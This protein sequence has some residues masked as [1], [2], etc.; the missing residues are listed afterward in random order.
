MVEAK[1]PYLGGGENK[2]SRGKM[3]L[4]GGVSARGSMNLRGAAPPDIARY[5]EGRKGGREE[6]KDSPGRMTANR[7]KGGEGREREHGVEGRE[8]GRQGRTEVVTWVFW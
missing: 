1:I 5:E 7:M 6:R 2:P 8:G 4:S 3:A